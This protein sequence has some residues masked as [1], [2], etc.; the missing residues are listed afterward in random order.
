VRR[1]AKILIGIAAVGA[2]LVGARIAAPAMVLRYVNRSLADMG[3][4]SGHVDS[5]DLVLWRGGYAARNLE[6]VK[7]EGKVETPFVSI[8]RTDLT[9]QWK[10]LWHGRVVGEMHMYA[11]VINVVQSESSQ[12]AQVGSGV[13]W[14]QEI[15]DLFPF[16]LNSVTADNGLITFR[17]PGIETDDSITMRDARFELRNLTNEQRR[18]K[19]AFA[20][21]ELEGRIMG[22]AP[23]KLTGQ[24]DPNEEA[25]TFDIDLSIEH[26][27]L[28]D[29]NPWLER[30]LK[31][32]AEAGEFSMYSELASARN[33]FEGYVKP[34]LES[35]KIFDAKQDSEG[36]FHKAWEALV[37]LAAK[38]LEN[39]Q[40]RQVATEIPLRG[41][42]E[43]PQAGLI[44][45]IVGL[46]RNAF[47][48][49]FSH[50]L[51]GSI[52]LR[53]VVDDVR[54]LGTDSKAGV[55][56]APAGDKKA[57]REQRRRERK[58]ESC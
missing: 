33:R 19:D 10:A 5:V 57:E 38:I 52:S 15:R 39:K 21:I 49:A 34:I 18:D 35:P 53:D 44:P 7:T 28:V 11:P 47:V 25:P 50:S 54:C 51:E 9:M 30:F 56:Q 23:L 24:I 58:H 1:R 32:D 26:G 42:I 4:Y 36:P 17:A 37:G 41:E 20:D 8:P 16:Q 12:E 40:A 13:N 29:F 45:A 43:S 14:P 2:V 55:A 27:R 46:A 3:A 6:I 22:N 48:A 31:V